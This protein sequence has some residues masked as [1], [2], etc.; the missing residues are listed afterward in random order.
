MTVR[1]A[2]GPDDADALARC[3]AAVFPDGSWDR[4]F[5]RGAL[6]SPHDVTLVLGQ[7]LHAFALFRLLGDEAE[8]LTIGTERRGEGAGA[9]L[10]EGVIARALAARA[11][12]LFLEVSDANKAARKLYDR[13][14]CVQTGRRRRY[15]A[16]GSDALTLRLELGE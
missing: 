10:L 16:D 12:R 3:H 4:A 8:L 9:V 14:G 6:A 5:W 11:K 1:L 7:P 13:F 2:Q 15:Y